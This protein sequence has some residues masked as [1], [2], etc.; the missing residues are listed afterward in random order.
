MQLVE[1]MHI[2]MRWV[3]MNLRSLSK[4]GV[5]TTLPL[6]CSIVK[7]HNRWKGNEN[8]ELWSDGKNVW[9]DSFMLHLG[10]SQHLTWQAVFPNSFLLLPSYFSNRCYQSANSISHC[11]LEISGN[12]PSLLE[13]HPP[14]ALSPRGDL[15]WLL[16]RILSFS[17]AQLCS[18]CLFPQPN[19]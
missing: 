7:L 19:P 12:Q 16:L 6:F 10:I 9:A 8:A 5:F 1:F 2:Q 4:S 13:E 18:W 15:I 17:M 3:K 11:T 14:M